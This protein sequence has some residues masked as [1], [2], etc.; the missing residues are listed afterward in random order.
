MGDALG[1]MSAWLRLSSAGAGLLA[2]LLASPMASRADTNPANDTSQF[3]IRNTPKDIFPP[4]PIT[5]LAG[6]AGAEGQALL[7]WTA[8]D[9]SHGVGRKPNVS[10]SSYTIH[11]ATFSAADLAGDTTAWFTASTPIAG[12]PPLNPGSPQALLTNLAPGVTIYFGIKSTDDSANLSESDS[13]LKTVVSQVSVPVKGIDGVTN[14]KALPGGPTGSIDLTWTHPRRVGQF[15]PAFYEMRISSTGQISNPAQFNAAQPLTALS[16]SPIPAV[17]P[18]GGAAA[19]TVTGLIPGISYA[20]AVRERDSGSFVGTWVRNVAADLNPFNFAQAKTLVAAPITDLTGLAGPGNGEVSLS[21]TAPDPVLLLNYRVF[22]ATFSVASVGGS[23]LTWRAL[24]LSSS[25]VIPAVAAPGSVQAA[26]LILTPGIRYYFG[27]ETTNTSG[28]GPLDSLA[29]GPQVAVRAKGLGAVTDLVAAS[30]PL[31]TGVN[32]TWTEPFVSSVTAPVSYQIKVS[33]LGFINGATDYAAAQT[34]SA[35]STIAVPSYAGGG[36]IVNVNTFGLTPFVTYYFAVALVDASTPPLVA[37]WQ[38]A[39]Y[40]DINTNTSALPLF[41]PNPPN[42]VSDLTALPGTAEGDV[43]LVWTAPA[44]ANLVPVSTYEVRFATF[45]ASSV[46]S[47]TTWTAAASSRAFAGALMAGATETRT[48]GGLFPASTWYFSIKSIDITNSIS[49]IDTKSTGTFQASTLPRSLPPSTPLNF[50]GTS[51]LRRGTLA[52]TDLTPAGKGLDFDYYR[53]ERSLDAISFVKMTTTTATGYVDF[54]LTAQVTYYYRLIAHDLR[55]NDSVA[56]ST[57]SVLP[58]TILPMEPLGVTVTATPT[59]VTLSW[60]PVTRFT[61]GSP[62]ISTGAPTI[63]EL[64]GYTVYRS[65]ESCGPLDFVHV[66][67]LPFI[68][69]SLLNNTGGLN[70]YYHIQSYNTQGLS[71]NTLTVSS[72]GERRFFLDQCDSMLIMD[73]ASAATLNAATNGRGAD[74][75]IAKTRRPQDV[76]GTIFQSAEWRGFALP[77]AARIML[78]YDTAG[79]IVVP[80]SAA[81]SGLSVAGNGA[82]AASI[83]PKDVGMYWDNGSEFKKMYGAVDVNAQTV[84]IESPNLGI[85]QVRALFRADG[86]VFDLSN[87]SNRVITPNGDGL[88]DQVIFTYDPGPRNAQVRGRIYDVTGA[89]VAEMAPGLVPNTIVWNGKMNGRSASSGVYVYKI[90]GDGKTYTGTVVVAR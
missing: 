35:I 25:T 65:T 58:Y 18:S 12:P 57:V 10:V 80:S 73:A 70:F 55:G 68:T 49:P 51:G 52:W 23:T 84:M 5:D 15:D 86:A 64:I 4:E 20:F 42:P 62:F 40:L 63:D 75:R 85:Y 22:H 78:H 13:Q 79:G 16:G 26:S 14:L 43:T 6:A 37:G 71:T 9:E 41:V 31:G 74:I 67:S 61:D 36:G 24:A 33:T 45:S 32:L 83:S 38:R 60:S 50:T 29:V 47:T 34:L 81:L 53:L 2:I 77:K 44:N 72:L 89:F 69:T 3:T 56:C 76:G 59:D 8:P 30:G 1:R 82:P 21:W 17:A 54:P 7:Q 90:E 11:Y 27:V 19:M 28:L 39:P 48:I 87:I 66:S 88:N 46:G